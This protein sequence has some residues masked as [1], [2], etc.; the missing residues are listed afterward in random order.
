MFLHCA[1][2]SSSITRPIQHRVWIKKQIQLQT[3][4]GECWQRPHQLTSI[5]LSSLKMRSFS[6]LLEKITRH[7]LMVVLM[8]VREISS[9]LVITK[10][11]WEGKLCGGPLHKKLVACRLLQHHLVTDDLKKALHL[12]F[13][14]GSEGTV[15]ISP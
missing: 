9:P 15:I 2:P 12:I 5:Y 13:L 6:S 10:F 14:E 3:N 4:E 8:T 7:R 11:F 1:L